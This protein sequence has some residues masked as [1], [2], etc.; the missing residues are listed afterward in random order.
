MTTPDPIDADLET[1]R[2]AYD[3][4]SAQ[5]AQA[6]L[7][8]A[9]CRTTLAA[10][11][12]QIA[13]QKTLILS[14]NDE[15]NRLEAELHPLTGFS[16]GVDANENNDPRGLPAIVTASR[17]L[18]GGDL[19][20][21][22]KFFDYG[23]GWKA[24]SD[25][26]LS[27]DYG[28]TPA[29]A[30]MVL[31]LAKSHD[32]TLVQA[33]EQLLPKFKTIVLVKDQEWDDEAVKA[34]SVAQYHADFAATKTVRDAQDWSGRVFMGACANAYAAL[35]TATTTVNLDTMYDGI[36][37]EHMGFD[38]YIWR[39]R[40]QSFDYLAQ[41]KTL[42]AYAHS[43][44]VPW[45]L[46]EF[47]A[48]QLKTGSD[49]LANVAAR[50]KAVIDFCRADPTCTMVNSWPQP[51]GKIGNGYAVPMLTSPVLDVLRAEQAA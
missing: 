15:I 36:G 23:A 33:V 16:V 30:S 9:D 45:G 46:T 43:L 17:A 8:L 13:A 24:A 29:E 41:L 35:D 14:Q 21:G 19:G 4:L 5:L 32:E 6:E 12:E 44:G 34:G 51:A 18:M 26:L 37:V 20:R 10:A 38:W 40:S 48:Q 1:A 39:F 11:D 31:L 7:D 49:T 27:T 47:G 2:A 3:N 22:G 42:Q 28:K 50:V 25:R